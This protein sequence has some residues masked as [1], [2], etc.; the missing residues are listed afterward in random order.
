MHGLN[1]INA[2][3]TQFQ[4]GDKV[5]YYGNAG[6]I[7]QIDVPVPG[8]S[9]PGALVEWDEKLIPPQM[10]VPYAHLLLINP[11]LLPVGNNPIGNSYPLS[12]QSNKDPDKYCPQCGNEWTQTYYYG[13]VW[14]DCTKCN[15]RKEDIVKNH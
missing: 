4:I 11:T 5:E 9:H 8:E 12:P 15:R 13:M 2:I 10:A 14:Y 6:T 7:I 3:N 1:V